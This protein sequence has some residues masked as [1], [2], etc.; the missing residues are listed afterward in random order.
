MVDIVHRVGIKG[1]LEGLL[2]AFDDR[3]LAAGGQR[4]RPETRKSAEPL[5][6]L[7]TPGETDRRVRHG[8][9]ELTPD[10]RVRWRVKGGPENGSHRVDFSL[11]GMT[12]HVVLFGHRNW[13]EEVE[14]TPTAARSGQRSCSASGNSSRAQAG[15]RPTTSGS[16]TGISE[17][18]ASVRGRS[19]QSR[20][21][22]PLEPISPKTGA[23]TCLAR[24][25][26]GPER[27]PDVAFALLFA[28]IA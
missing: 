27:A 6:S 17:C 18:V 4:Q 20:V 9:L 24:A 21:P 28:R 11:S 14:F 12:L 1:A 16:V 8:V 25:Q 2:G 5:L 10:E 19:P 7:H 23:E 26:A 15:L 13:R 3:R 22:V